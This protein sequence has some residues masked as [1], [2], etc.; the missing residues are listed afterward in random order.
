MPLSY[1]DQQVITKSPGVLHF[2]GKIT[3]LQMLKDDIPDIK[4]LFI[5][6]NPVQRIIGD[7]IHE[8][9]EGYYRSLQ[10]HMIGKHGLSFRGQEMPP[11]DDIIMGRTDLLLAHGFPDGIPGMVKFLSDYPAQLEMLTQVFPREQVHV[12]DG[13]KMVTN[14]LPEIKKIEQFLEI[15]SFFSEEHF[16]FPEGSKFPCFR[17]SRESKPKC[18]EGDKGRSHPDLLPETYEHLKMYFS[19]KMD[20]FFNM[21][22]IKYEL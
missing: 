22:G 11:L 15:P 8:Y 12:I 17:P 5:V 16:Y 9:I 2:P 1:P 14:P 6:K 18:M 3:S 10:L 20:T 21:T 19:P 13:E 7:I 4:L